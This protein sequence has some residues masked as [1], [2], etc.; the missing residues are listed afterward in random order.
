MTTPFESGKVVCTQPHL[1]RCA[2]IKMKTEITELALKY[3]FKLQSPSL[4]ALNE[5]ASSE[6]NLPT[7]LRDFYT[8]T[9]GLQH[10]WF[11]IPPLYDPANPK[12]T[13]DSLQR[14]NDPEH[15][16]FLSNIELSS[17]YLI[18]AEI[19]GPDFA[20]ILRNDE[21][22]WFSEGKELYQTDLSLT[23]FI[24]VCLK[25]VDEI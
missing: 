16:K 6:L 17:E 25:E 3:K 18:F 12:H 10:E 13:W 23:E 21:S 19:S 2:E 4:S 1:K 7:G 5:T 11:R 14:A 9:N 15:S 22:I 20:A 8:I 24:S